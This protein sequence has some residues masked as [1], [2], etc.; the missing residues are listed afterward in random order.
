MALNRYNLFCNWTV[1]RMTITYC[2]PQ[3]VVWP[4]CS[5]MKKALNSCLTIDI[6]GKRS[7]ILHICRAS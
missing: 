2:C 5:Y 1:N 7:W 3:E 6:S 4:C